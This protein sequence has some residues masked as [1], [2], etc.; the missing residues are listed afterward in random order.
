MKHNT[1]PSPGKPYD[2]E[3]LNPDEE[4]LDLMRQAISKNS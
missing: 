4:I 3:Q 2:D 1:V